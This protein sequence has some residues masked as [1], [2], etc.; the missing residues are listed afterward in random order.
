MEAEVAGVGA[1][2]GKEEARGHDSGL[3]TTAPARGGRSSSGG[4][5]V[6]G[7][8]EEAEGKRR[9]GG[10][11]MG[12]RSPESGPKGTGRGAPPLATELTSRWRRVDEEAGEEVLARWR[13]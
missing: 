6:R 10:E 8:D 12:R 7:E 3:G 11:S 2:E 4:G 5:G 13:A 9:G 1:W